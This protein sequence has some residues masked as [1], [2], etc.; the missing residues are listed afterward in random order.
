MQY[1]FFR[2][3]SKFV[4]QALSVVVRAFV[5][6]LV[7]GMCVVVMMHFLGMPVPSANQVWQGLAG[8][9]RLARFS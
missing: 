8:L 6:M 7:F 3:V 9:S 2:A 4:Q 1:P 5:T